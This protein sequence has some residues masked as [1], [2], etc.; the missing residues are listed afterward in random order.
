MSSERKQFRF[1][2][3]PAKCANWL[4]EAQMQWINH[5]KTVLLKKK[6]NPDSLFTRLSIY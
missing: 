5:S 6:K 4:K 1:G 3:G 2:F